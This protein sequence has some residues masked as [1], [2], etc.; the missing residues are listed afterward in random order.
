[1]TPLELRDLL[2]TR[3]PAVEGVASAVAWP[4]RPY[5]LEVALSSGG[6]AYWMVTGASGVAPAAVGGERPAPLAVPEFPADRVPLGLVEQAVTAVVV[7]AAPG[8]VRL[9]RY[10]LRPA[11]PAVVFGA[12][13]DCEDGWRLFVSAVGVSTGPGARLRRVMPDS[14]VY[15]AGSRAPDGGV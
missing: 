2:V 5:G 3:L 11:P 1:M 7:Q 9:D 10:G 8:V 15:A 13:V 12:T 4:E 6:C 14:E